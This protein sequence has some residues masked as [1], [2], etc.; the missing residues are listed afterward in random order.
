[1]LVGYFDADDILT[2]ANPAFLRSYDAT[3]GMSWSDLLRHNH[4][5]QV[6]CRIRTDDFEAWL[7]SVRGRRAK[8]PYRSFEADF[9]DGR[10]VWMTEIVDPAGGMLCIASDIT[11]LR[12]GERDLRQSRDRA[13]RFAYTDALT[14]IGNR[15][16]GLAL[17]E[18][19]MERQPGSLSVALLD[20][21]HFKQINDQHGHAHGDEVLRD[22]AHRLSHAIRR[23]DTCARLGG[24]EFLLVLPD[25]LPADAGHLLERLFQQL[26][27]AS[28]VP[29]GLDYRCSAGIAAWQAGDTLDLLLRR[30]DSALYQAKSLG[31][32]QWQLAP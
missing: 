14:G 8:V 26:R 2:Y 27:D 25:T 24:E 4:A 15:R 11:S 21:D 6:G 16:H 29:G 13:L 3:L 17:L 23:D 10:W 28:L 18:A 7:L 1:M 22:F 5:H 9:L 31:R 32:D 30:A 20:L 12:P 19:A